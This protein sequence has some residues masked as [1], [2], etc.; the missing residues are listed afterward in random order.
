MAGF[1]ISVV[2]LVFGMISFE[3]PD[4]FKYLRQHDNR[5]L[6]LK[7][8]IGI[9]IILSIVSLILAIKGI[10]S[11]REKGCSGKCLA[12][13]A[14]LIISF[15][16]MNFAALGISAIQEATNRESPPTTISSTT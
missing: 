12:V 5:Y 9:V 11:C 6:L 16:M 13:I 3:L 8:T 2:A 4:H 14:I 15:I 10:I 1:I 7:W